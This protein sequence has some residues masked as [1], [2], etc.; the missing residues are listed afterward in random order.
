[1]E[2]RD[3]FMG[4]NSILFY[5]RFPDEDSCYQYLSAIKWEE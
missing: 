2:K 1:M 4:V 5:K 3:K